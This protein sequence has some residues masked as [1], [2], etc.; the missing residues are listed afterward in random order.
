MSLEKQEQAVFVKS[1][2][3]PE[4]IQSKVNGYDFNN[5]VDYSK[6][7]ESYRHTGF[8]ATALSMA[9]G[10]ISRMVGK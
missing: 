9:I 2:P 4:Q 1:N 7:L 8:Q 3:L 6:L 10:E 5:G